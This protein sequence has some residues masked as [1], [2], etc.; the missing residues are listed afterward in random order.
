MTTA[1]EISAA[2][3]DRDPASLRK[4]EKARLKRELPHLFGWNWYRW[5][6]AFFE[7]ICRMNLLVAANQIGKS[8]IQIRKC[9]HWATDTSI[10][11]KL[12]PLNPTPRQFWYLYPTS[13]I[14]TTEFQNKWVPEIMPKRGNFISERFKERCDDPVYGWKAVYEKKKIYAIAWNSGVMTYFK[15]YSQNVHSLQAGSCHAIFTDEELPEDLYDELVFRIKATHGYFS[16][17][18]TA[19]R[20]QMLWMLAMEGEGEMEKFPNAFKQQIEM[21]DCME[22]E[23]GTPGHYTEEMI[24]EAIEDCKNETEVDRRVRGRFVTE[25]GRK[26]GAFVPSKH[27]IKP[28]DIPRDWKFYGGVDP[29]S[30]GAGGHPTGMGIIAV[31]P[32]YRYGVVCKGWRGD[33]IETTAGDALD[34]YIIM[35]GGIKCTF[36]VYDH[37]C[38]DFHTIAT[39]VGEPFN[40]AEKSHEVGEQVVNTLFKNTML[41]VFDTPELRKLGAELM[42]LNRDTH[43]KHAKDDL[44][45]GALRYPATYIPWDWTAIRDELSEEAQEAKKKSEADREWTKEEFE[46]E[47]IRLR[48]GEERKSDEKGG[49]EETTQEINFWNDQ[50][51]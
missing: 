31:R 30:G 15:T 9:I 36:Q 22:Y 25:I 27:F 17:V 51:G 37:A 5:N 12:W 6:R 48:R 44:I 8:T 46:A 47:Q 18:F 34:H 38:K 14:A 7:S 21:Y 32:D 41:Q 23:D 42:T 20:N 29:G 26:Y 4:A 10:W 40:K 11:A 49:W 35:R 33:G 45:D 39:R 1:S 24:K 13:D 2:N 3:R 50:Y 16:M 28:F 19:T 43:K